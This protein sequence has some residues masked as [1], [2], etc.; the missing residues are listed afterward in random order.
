MKKHSILL[1]ALAFVLTVL[2]S[3][4]LNAQTACCPD[5][6]LS[7][8][9]DICPTE[10]ACITDPAGGS[11][12][13]MHMRAACKE[14]AHVYTV[15]PNEPGFTFT[16]TVSGGTAFSSTGNPNTIVWGTGATG[17]ITVYISNLSGTCVD[18]ISEEICLIDGPDASFT[19]SPNPVCQNTNVNF[20]NT[21]AGGSS[22]LWDFGDGNNSA[23]ED[24]L[25]QYDTSGTFAVT[26]TTYKC[27]ESDESTQ[28]VIIDP[29]MGIATSNTLNAAITV[30]PNPAR[31]F[32]T[33]DIKMQYKHA[34]LEIYNLLG[35]KLSQ[36]ELQHT[37]KANV[38][39]STLQAGSYF[40]KV[41]LDN[42]NVSNIRFTKLDR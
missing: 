35:N 33:V 14:T 1:G 30:Y 21:S 16:W 39:I 27:G 37:A 2:S 40:I 11:Q 7:D 5:F 20:T 15:F 10:G 9:V 34:T 38:D 12:G 23:Q 13:F 29:I 17:T 41:L 31:T 36:Q 8:A 25:H 18:S 32:L 4:N 42:G 24:P 3:L 26:L 28:Q 19:A 22:Y 6:F